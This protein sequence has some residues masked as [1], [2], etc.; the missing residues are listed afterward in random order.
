MQPLCL[1]AAF[2]LIAFAPKTFADYSN[3][4]QS[5]QQTLLNLTFDL[6]TLQFLLH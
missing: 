3:L 6:E 4:I 5:F 2:E 1:M